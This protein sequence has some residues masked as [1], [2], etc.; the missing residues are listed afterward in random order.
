MKSEAG[1]PLCVMD[2]P[3]LH[4]DFRVKVTS[5]ARPLLTPVTQELCRYERSVWSVCQHSLKAGI[6]QSSGA[7]YALNKPQR[8]HGTVPTFPL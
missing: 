7:S 3:K 5:V 6:K 1:P 8:T 4:P 2:S